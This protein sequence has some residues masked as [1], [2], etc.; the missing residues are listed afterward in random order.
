MCT[1]ATP[2]SP[3]RWNTSLLRASADRISHLTLACHAC[4]QTK[5]NQTAA[6]FG[7][8]DIQAQAGA[9]SVAIWSVVQAPW[10]ISRF[11]GDGCPV[12]PL[13]RAGVKSGA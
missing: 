6:E 10:R 7:Y 3:W 4:N 2:M 11:S 13:A 9:V 5:G 8:P 12:S 1:A